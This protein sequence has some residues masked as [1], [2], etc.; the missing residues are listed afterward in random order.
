LVSELGSINQ[1]YPSEIFVLVVSAKRFLSIQYLLLLDFAAY[2]EIFFSFYY[3]PKYISSIKKR[4][5]IVQKDKRFLP[6][7]TKQVK[8]DSN[9]FRISSI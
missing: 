3:C 2:Q 1:L 7:K 9:Q 8:I 4:K 5:E 6:Q